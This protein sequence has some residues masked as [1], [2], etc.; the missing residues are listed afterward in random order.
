MNTYT[1][2]AILSRKDDSIAVDGGGQLLFF[3][4][5]EYKK[6]MKRLMKF[7]NWEF[8]KVETITFHT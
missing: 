6:A 1:V 4:K 7:E 5:D 8:Y 2:W 3:K